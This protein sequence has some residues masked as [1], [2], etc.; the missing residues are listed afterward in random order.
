MAASARFVAELTRCQRHLHA[1]ICSVVWNLAEAD[2]VLQE[3]NLVLWQKA[4]HYDD[5]RDFLTWAM[6]FAQ[7][8]S[9][10]WLKRRHR[11]PDLLKP[12]VLEL[13][14]SEAIAEAAELDAHRRALSACIEKLPADHRSLIVRRYGGAASV[15]EMAAARQ[16]SPKALSELLRRI[17]R[18]LLNCIMK[19]LTEE[20]YA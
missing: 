18:A 3:T 11:L 1:F 2:D 13:M 16:T 7:L 10:A 8:Q 14:V 15:N 19:S 9:M 12:R 5:S 6:R 17:R 20:A 4:D